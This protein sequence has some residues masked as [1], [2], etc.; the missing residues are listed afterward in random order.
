M[1]AII[2]YL[3]VRYMKD[4]LFTL[5]LLALIFFGGLG[6]DVIKIQF[7]TF[8]VAVLILFILK[9]KN[10][11]LRIPPFFLHYILYVFIIFLSIF[12][13][14]SV[15]NTFD[16]LILYVDG[17]LFWLILYNISLKSVKLFLKGVVIIGIIFGMLFVYGILMHVKD[18]N[19]FTLFSPVWIGSSHVHIGDYWMISLIVFLFYLVNKKK[20]LTRILLSALT[21]I[22]FA[23]LIKSASRSAVLGLGIGLYYLFSAKY[24]FK[25]NSK[26]SVLLISILVL[27][28]LFM[29]NAK[30]TLFSRGYFVQ[31]IVGLYRN[32]FGIGMGNFYKIST[33]SRNQIF[34]L[35]ETSSVAHN[36]I[37]ENTS[38][39]GVFGFVF[40]FWLFSILMG[41]P[42]KKRNLFAAVFIALTVNFMFDFTYIIPTMYLLW[43]SFLGLAQRKDLTMDRVK[44][45]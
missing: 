11:V 42:R 43:L 20:S 14:K 29:S 12:W 8:I 26:I 45:F 32:P 38:G 33:D 6:L 37:I 39:V 25:K 1:I 40:V 3:I 13:V 18:V 15:N 31:G 34:G 24:V 30:T 44:R 2:L 19:S 7:Y 23:F 4:S 21:L 22:G 35:K 5:I 16:T 36:I 17:E 41:L 10:K 27:S 9:I 28:F